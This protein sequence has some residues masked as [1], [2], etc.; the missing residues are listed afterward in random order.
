MATF[1]IGLFSSFVTLD[2][3][4]VLTSTIPPPGYQH[5]RY[6]WSAAHEPRRWQ[7]EGGEVPAGEL[8]SEA[9]DQGVPHDSR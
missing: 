3:D 1:I 5:E 7:E 9:A 2:K 4:K 8:L 6:L